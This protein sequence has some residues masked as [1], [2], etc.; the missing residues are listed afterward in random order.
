MAAVMTTRRMSAFL[1]HVSEQNHPVA[2]VI[3]IS[4]LTGL[5][6]GPAMSTVRNSRVLIHA[7]GLH[8]VVTATRLLVRTTVISGPAIST[9]HTSEG[10]A[11]VLLALSHTS[12]VI[13]IPFPDY[14]YDGFCYKYKRSFASSFTCNGVTAGSYCYCLDSTSVSNCVSCSGH[15]YR[16]T[17]YPYKTYVG[18]SGSCA[19]GVKSDSGHCYSS[20]CPAHSHSGS[21]YK[22]SKYLGRYQSCPGVRAKSWCYFDSCPALYLGF[23]FMYKTAQESYDYCSGVKSRDGY[24]YHDMDVHS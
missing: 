8:Q 15:V 20:S 21:C 13:L 19:N 17:C 11:H 23:C 2:I 24:C 14:P 7:V 1:G 22:Y 5:T 12:T 10:Q 4:A 9:K 6:M 16:G 18:S 3:D